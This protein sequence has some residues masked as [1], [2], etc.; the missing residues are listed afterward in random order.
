MLKQDYKDEITREEGVQLAL[1]VLSKTM[2]STS[3]T[4]EKLE[5][6]EIFL[7]PTGEVKYQVCKLE[8]LERLLVKV[9]KTD[10]I[11]FTCKTPSAGM[12]TEKLYTGNLGNKLNPQVNSGIQIKQDFLASYS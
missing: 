3:L 11:N 8:L 12:M 1:K 6:A 5:P 9:E 4:S 7:E 2:D 10:E